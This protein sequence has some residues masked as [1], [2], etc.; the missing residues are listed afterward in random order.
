[1][2]SVSNKSLKL[3]GKDDNSYKINNFRK[4][5]SK[6]ISSEPNKMFFLPPIAKDAYKKSLLQ[7]SSILTKFF[8]QFHEN[9]LKNS[10]EFISTNFSKNSFTN[11][12]KSKNENNI[13]PLSER[14]INTNNSNKD[15]N[16][17]RN[18]EKNK[19]NL[20]GDNNHPLINQESSKLFNRK[21]LYLTELRKKAK[22]LSPQLSFST[23]KNES[24]LSNEIKKS[25]LNLN[26]ISQ[27]QPYSSYPK[28]IDID[29]ELS[30]EEYNKFDKLFRR[31]KTY[32][33][34][35]LVNWKEKCG[36]FYNPGKKDYIPEFQK[37]I[38][39]QSK[40]L[41]DQTKL[42]EGNIKYYKKNLVSKNNFEEV[43]NSMSLKSKIDFNKALEETIGIMF[44]L[45]RLIL[46]DFYEIIKKFDTMKI[47]DK[48]KLRDKY[49]FDEL[50]NLR[51]NNNLL[52]EICDYYHSCF[53]VYLI[54]IN[55]VDDM[56]LNNKNFEN[57]ISS[58][59]KARFNILYVTN[60][61]TNALNY[62]DKDI[63]FINRVNN[64]LGL[65]K[66][67]ISQN[68]LTNKMMH[69]FM[70]KKN[71]ER[72]KKIMIESCLSDGNAEDIEQK[73]KKIKINRYGKIMKEN[74]RPKFKSLINSKLISNLLKNCN[75][76]AKDSINSE[77]ITNQMGDDFYDDEGMTSKVKRKVI[78]INF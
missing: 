42:L 18:D 26:I 21:Q 46:S 77:I 76:E 65:K 33:P 1:M 62:Y 19:I 12:K 7:Q 15:I 50:E 68:V 71:P 3:L 73:N 61:A 63:E 64:K 37:D 14:N 58:F 4:S 72:Q 2:K 16:I 41:N 38:D 45:P 10:E 24:K 36:L 23:S 31:K 67:N 47:P 75:K 53:E 54:L 56:S 34:I 55:E 74:K 27:K 25:Y 78:K 57:V 66:K 13:N 22:L 20:S 52:S 59:E 40:L 8:H 49:V 5:N 60:S 28:M 6:I 35:I 44:L 29:E 11:S 30:Q 39:Y 17:I 32:Q 70:F 69:Q 51:Y 43:F 48:K 9:F